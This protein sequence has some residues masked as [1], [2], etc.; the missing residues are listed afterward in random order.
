MDSIN[1]LIEFLSQ[2]RESGE[3]VLME[4]IEESIDEEV[5]GDGE[6]ENTEDKTEQQEEKNNKFDKNERFNLL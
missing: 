1:V 6:E 4:S 3:D 2:T 5:I